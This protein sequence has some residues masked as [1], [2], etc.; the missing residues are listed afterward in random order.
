LPRSHCTAPSGLYAARQPGCI[1]RLTSVPDNLPPRH[2]VVHLQLCTRHYSNG[3]ALYQVIEAAPSQM[4]IALRLQP[5]RSS[6][7]CTRAQV[8]RMQTSRARLSA[9]PSNAYKR[10]MVGSAPVLAAPLRRTG[11]CR[12]VVPLRKHLPDPCI[13]TTVC[14]SPRHNVSSGLD[15]CS[16][17]PGCCLRHAQC[18]RCQKS[19]HLFETVC[20]EK[21]TLPRRST[22]LLAPIC[23][24]QS[25]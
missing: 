13:P 17:C 5:S 9:A 10:R 15:A 25:R 8:G 4:H 11:V 14:L 3:C 23:N 2:S 16:N 19:R 18:V 22:Q 7:C 12:A 21:T 20:L 6:R 1:F 24:F